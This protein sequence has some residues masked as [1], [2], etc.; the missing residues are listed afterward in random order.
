M[1]RVIRN[2]YANVDWQTN[3]RHKANMHTHT[4]ESDGANT[5]AEMI[6][7]YHDL[8]YTI[9]AL[10]DHD[11]MGP[12]K[13]TWPWTDYGRDPEQLGMLAVGP[14][15]EYS[16]PDHI[17]GFWCDLWTQEDID[18]GLWAAHQSDIPWILNEVGE[19]GGLAQI[20][21]PGRY[22][23]SDQFYLDLFDAYHPHTPGI[24]VYNKGN[25][26]PADKPRWDR[27][28]TAMRQEGETWPLWGT[29][30]DDAH[31]VSGNMPVGR[32]FHIYLLPEL[33]EAALRQA[34]LDG[35]FYF[36]YDPQGATDARHVNAEEE[37][38]WHAAPIIN[39]INVTSEAITID[40]DQQ[41]S[42]EWF[43]DDGTSVHV[44][45][46]LPLNTEGLGGY[47][48]AEL[49]GADSSVTHTQP[50]FL[51]PWLALRIGGQD[52]GVVR[53]RRDGQDINLT[54]LRRP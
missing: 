17:N 25:N 31:N 29:S 50:F 30:V 18:N 53:L 39:S 8:G 49:Y 4:T 12:Q 11:T 37:D 54:D 33:T 6:D 52:R 46:T 44:G 15:N 32:N 48:R 16:R 41:T 42:T 7:R 10:T 20:N 21:H 9:L 3:G 19:R 43:T 24:E 26:Y 27:L 47:V 28:L 1:K 36:V 23:R 13:P 22:S 38:W 2:P 5:P 40:A 35:A 34:M 14:S 51:T 45:D